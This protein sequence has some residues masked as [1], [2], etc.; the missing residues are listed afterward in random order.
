[1]S[2]IINFFDRGQKWKVSYEGPG[3]TASVSTRGQVNLVVGDGEKTAG[4]TLPFTEFV[5]M[6]SQ[7]SESLEEHVDGVLLEAK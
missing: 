7:L 6:L 1:M 4:V 5:A 3:V 2:N